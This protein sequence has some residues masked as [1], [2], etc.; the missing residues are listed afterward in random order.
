MALPPKVSANA[1]DRV[2]A[3]AL[4]RL[5]GGCTC[6]HLKSEHAAASGECMALERPAGERV[7]PE[8]RPRPAV[9]ASCACRAYTVAPPPP[10]PIVD[11]PPLG[12]C[13]ARAL[14]GLSLASEVARAG[15]GV[16]RST[17][18]AWW[19]AWRERGAVPSP[20]PSRA[21]RF[22]DAHAEILRDH[23]RTFEK[24]AQEPQT[25]TRP[26]PHRCGVSDEPCNGWP[27]TG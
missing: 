13:I 11:R 14:E 7:T 23:A 5:P 24:L 10:P 21:E 19:A 26:A 18:E 4:G 20:P 16:A 12:G 6:W 27:R 22:N 25:C 17:I 9:L 15:L 8:G 3:A 2:V 1:V